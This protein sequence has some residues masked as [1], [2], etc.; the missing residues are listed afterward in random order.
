MVQNDHTE[1]ITTYAVAHC[2][3]PRCATTSSALC[4]RTK[5][6]MDAADPDTTDIVFVVAVGLAL[7]P[8]FVPKALPFFPFH[9]YW[10]RK[11]TPIVFSVAGV[12][13]LLVALRIR[14]PA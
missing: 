6:V 1:L 5:G 9:M 14:H 2:R 3:T 13:V 7:G 11:S 4:L 8:S 10:P 12:V